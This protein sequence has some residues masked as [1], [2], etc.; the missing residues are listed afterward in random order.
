MQVNEIESFKRKKNQRTV[1][2]LQHVA[3]VEEIKMHESFTGKCQ[4]I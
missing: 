3:H 4:G 1:K 2:W